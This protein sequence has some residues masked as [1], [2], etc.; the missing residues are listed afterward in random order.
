MGVYDGGRVQV[1]LSTFVRNGTGFAADES[2][3]SV[4]RS[5][6]TGNKAAVALGSFAYVSIIDSSFTGS[7]VAVSARS[8]AI[9]IAGSTFVSNQTAV[10]ISEDGGSIVRSKFQQN[11]TTLGFVTYYGPGRSPTLVQDDTFTQNANGLYVPSSIEGVQI[12]RSSATSNT[13]WGIF[14]PGSTDLGGNTARD[15][16]NVP[17]CVGVVCT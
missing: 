10:Q 3:G 4:E 7:T 1:V 12:G 17:Q 15:N 9:D 11:G 14:A 2:S 8:S 6:F 16:R 13:G 5:T